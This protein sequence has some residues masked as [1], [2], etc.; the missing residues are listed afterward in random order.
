MALDGRLVAFDRSVT[1]FEQVDLTLGYRAK[2]V[3][4]VW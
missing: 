1:G 4:I 2:A 3:A